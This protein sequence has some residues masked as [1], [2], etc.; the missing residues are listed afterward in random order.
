MMT[1]DKFYNIT[2]FPFQTFGN[3]NTFVAALRITQ[4]VLPMFGSQL[5]EFDNVMMYAS[6]SHTAKIKTIL[7]TYVS[8]TDKQKITRYK[9]PWTVHL[10]CWYVSLSLSIFSHRFRAWLCLRG[11]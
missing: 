10:F 6:I 1:G 3:L 11:G 2:S 8:F 9:L 5:N 7:R 4:F